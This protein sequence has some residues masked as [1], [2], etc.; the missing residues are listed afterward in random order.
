MYHAPNTRSGWLRVSLI[1]VDKVENLDLKLKESIK[2]WSTAVVDEETGNVVEVSEKDSKEG[3][4]SIHIYYWYVSNVVP[5]RIYRRAVFSYTILSEYKECKEN[6]EMVS[7]LG[8]LVKRATFVQ[9]PQDR[10]YA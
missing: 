5:P 2:D 1:T 3:G 7:L 4:D 10:P 8:D 6:L 9:I